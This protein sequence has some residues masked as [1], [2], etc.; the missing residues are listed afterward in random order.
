MLVREITSEEKKQF[1]AVVHHPC[2]TWEWGEFRQQMGQTVFRLGVFERDKL[3]SAYQFTLHQL[4]R[5]FGGQAYTVGY[6]P[7]GPRPDKNMLPALEKIGREQKTIFFRIEPNISSGDLAAPEFKGLRFK[8]LNLRPASRPFF[9]QQTFLIDLTKSDSEL[10]ALMKPKTR[11]NLR[12][13]QRQGVK[14]SEDNSDQVFSEY[15]RLLKET[16]QRQG[17]FAHTEEYHRQMWQALRPTGIARLLKAEY[18][19][20]ILAVW[21]LFHWQNILYYPYGASSSWYRHFMA[22]NL[23]MWEAMKLGKKLGCQTF[24]LWGCL[25][26]G[27]DPSPRH[28]WYGF[29][30]FKEGYGGR[31]VKF[32]GSFD[33]VLQPGFYRLYNFAD[34][35]RWSVLQIKNRLF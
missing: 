11:Y 35:L 28:P 13:A 22:S 18:Q 9:Y 25:G 4:P 24:D 21:I 30:R 34:N 16:T 12:L 14:I 26:G 3:I 6:F 27:A 20:Q 1:N 15:L 8:S 33:L 19:G 5:P 17:F 29:H 2:Q 31:L 10:L 32:I 23:M 7:R